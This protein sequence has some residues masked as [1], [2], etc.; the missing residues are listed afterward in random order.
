MR[1]GGI[2]VNQEGTPVVNRWRKF[3][4]EQLFPPV[5]RLCRAPGRRGVDLCEACIADLPWLP[6]GCRQCGQP[7]AVAGA[8]LCGRCLARPPAFDGCISLFS[9]EFPID[10]LI[11][12]IKFNSDL[13][14]ARSLGLLLSQRLRERL[15]PAPDRVIP[16]PLHWRRLAKRGFNQALELARPL[17]DTGF[18]VDGSLCR[19]IRRTPAQSGLSAARRRRNLRGAFE[20]TGGV[21]GRRIAV[22]DDVMTT[23][24]TLDALARTLKRA[25]AVRVEAWVIARTLK[26]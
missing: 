25:G 8:G 20:V 18:V 16:V 3:V 10:Q 17:A 24:S 19:R 15:E 12:R 1:A 21:R 11:Q 26:Q 5:C 4:Q 13:A 6:P 14:M 23:G 22:I 7:L 9:Y 2:S